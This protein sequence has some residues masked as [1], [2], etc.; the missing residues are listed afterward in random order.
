MLGD[1]SGYCLSVRQTAEALGIS[2][3]S[4]YRLVGEGRLPKLRGVGDRV[5]IPRFALERWVE[6]NT[7]MADPQ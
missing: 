7:E 6:A 5:L 2:E 1:V 3:S 4:V